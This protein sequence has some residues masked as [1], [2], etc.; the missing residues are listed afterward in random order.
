MPAFKNE[1]EVM[2]GTAVLF[3]FLFNIFASYAFNC[4]V[5]SKYGTVDKFKQFEWVYVSLGEWVPIN[6]LFLFSTLFGIYKIGE[7]ALELAL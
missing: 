4:I 6:F 5:L 3:N 7:Q 2:V 1:R